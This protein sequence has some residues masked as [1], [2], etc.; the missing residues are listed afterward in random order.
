MSRMHKMGVEFKMQLELHVKVGVPRVELRM[1]V[2]M[3]P[4]KL[5]NFF[6]KSHNR[7]VAKFSK[8]YERLALT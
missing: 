7:C 6:S 4:K 3:G 5:M 1:Q 2:E 8:K